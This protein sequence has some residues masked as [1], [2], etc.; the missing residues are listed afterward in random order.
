LFHHFFQQSRPEE[1][2]RDG[3]FSYVY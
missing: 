2:P 1:L 3:F